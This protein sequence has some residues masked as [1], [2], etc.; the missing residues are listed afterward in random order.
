MVSEQ[1]NEKGFGERRAWPNFRKYLD[2]YPERQRI[3]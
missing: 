1:M 2:I 3:P